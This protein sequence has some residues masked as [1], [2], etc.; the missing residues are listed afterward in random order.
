MSRKRDKV[1]D[2]RGHFPVKAGPTRFNVLRPDCQRTSGVMQ[3]FERSE[4]IRF[5]RWSD[6]NQFKH[7]ASEAPILGHWRDY[8]PDKQAKYDESKGAKPKWT[9]RKA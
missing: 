3:G 7:G 9:I 1:G 2:K 8:K 5:H 6:T 4:P